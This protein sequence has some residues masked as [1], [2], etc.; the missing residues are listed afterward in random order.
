MLEVGNGDLTQ[1]ENV[2]H[3]IL[4]CSFISLLWLVCQ[5]AGLD[6]LVTVEMKS[7]HFCL[8]MRCLWLN[9]RYH[10]LLKK[11]CEIRLFTELSPN[12]ALAVD[13]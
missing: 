2:A 9:R 5:L 11:Q 8:V 6:S 1:N 10:L 7:G 3:M 13:T 4:W 12:V